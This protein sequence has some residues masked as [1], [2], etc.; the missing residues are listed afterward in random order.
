MLE[1]KAVEST[2]VAG[3]RQI[4]AEI[5]GQQPQDPLTGKAG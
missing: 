1:I 4:Y 2:N 3:N 5:P